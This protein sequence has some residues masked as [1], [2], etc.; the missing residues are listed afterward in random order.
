[1]CM[2]VCDIYIYIIEIYLDIFFV[3]FGINVV[4]DVVEKQCRFIDEGKERVVFLWL[5]RV[6][7]R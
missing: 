3:L 2:Y 1:M 4:Y 5:E 6:Y 7:I